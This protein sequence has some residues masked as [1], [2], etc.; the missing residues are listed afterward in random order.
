MITAVL[1]IYIGVQM[2][3]P[4]WYMVLCWVAFFVGLYR[5]FFRGE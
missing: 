1:L 4:V 5:L 2:H 3:F